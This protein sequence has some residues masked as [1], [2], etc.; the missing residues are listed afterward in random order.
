MFRATA[1]NPPQTPA[2]PPGRTKPPPHQ[3]APTDEQGGVPLAGRVRTG[4]EGCVRDAG[5][6]AETTPHWLRHTAA[7]WLMEAGV[8]VWL[9]AAYLG[10]TPETL[11]KVYGHVRPDYQAE[12]AGSFGRR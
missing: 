4:F 6:D 10:M 8:D 12:A 1:P 3:R 11:I 9:S 7:T 5:L 2:K